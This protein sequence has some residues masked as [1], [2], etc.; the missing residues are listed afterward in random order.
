MCW[1]WAN[2][3]S[4]LHWKG[5]K[6]CQ[7]AISLLYRSN[8]R[9][10]N[11]IRKN[12]TVS[13]VCHDVRSSKYTKTKN[14]LHDYHPDFSITKLIRDQLGG[15]GKFHG[16]DSLWK[17][18]GPFSIPTKLLKLLKCFLSKPLET[19]FN[20]SF[21]TGMVPDDFKVAKVIPIYKKG[22]KSILVLEIIVPFHF[23][24][25]ST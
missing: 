24:L 10:G 7:C 9:L 6:K 5:N 13:G 21:T 8:G 2:R 14:R 23:C 1:G 19:I 22:L 15:W 11:S 20:V 3:F 4:V 25:F 17:A 12:L 16:N 18:C